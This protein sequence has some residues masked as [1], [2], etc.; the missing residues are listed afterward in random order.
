[1][2]DSIEELLKMIITVFAFV[3]AVIVCPLFLFWLLSVL[4]GSV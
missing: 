3:L 4:I 1:M 2:N